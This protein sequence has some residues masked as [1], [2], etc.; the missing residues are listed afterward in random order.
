[1][2]SIGTLSDTIERQLAQADILL[3]TKVDL[4]AQDTLDAVTKWLREKVPAT[5]ILTVSRGEV[6]VSAVLGV[7]C[8]YLRDEVRS[9]LIRATAVLRQWY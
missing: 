3:L 2:P 9:L 1:M 4:V 8:T 7:N 5:R 6:P